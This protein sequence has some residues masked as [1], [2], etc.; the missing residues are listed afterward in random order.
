MGVGGL[1]SGRSSHANTRAQGRCPCLSPPHATPSACPPPRHTHLHPPPH[2]HACEHCGFVKVA[3]SQWVPSAK[4]G[5]P[6]P[7][8]HARPLG[9]SV[10]HLFLHAIH[11]SRGDEGALGGAWVCRVGRAEGGECVEGGGCGGEEGKSTARPNRPPAHATTPP[12]PHLGL[13]RCQRA[14]CARARPVPPQPDRRWRPACVCVWVGVCVWGGARTL[15]GWV[16]EDSG[17][18]RGWR[19][20]TRSKWRHRGRGGADAGAQTNRSPHPPT[21]QPTNL[22]HTPSPYTRTLRSPATHP[23]PQTR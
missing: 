9:Q 6:P 20:A 21:H 19:G 4:G 1:Q 2:K 5:S 14:A 13:A 16:G 10:S 22:T 23:H 17:W 15:G 7:A 8:R 11:S 3:P 12:A 18:M